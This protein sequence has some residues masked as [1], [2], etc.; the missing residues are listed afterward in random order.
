MSQPTNTALNSLKPKEKG[1]L[2]RYLP[3]IYLRNISW[4]P[5]IL[6]ALFA[7][8]LGGIG[9]SYGS[10]DIKVL[11]FAA[12]AGIIVALAIYQKPELGAY[13]LTIMVFTNASDLLTDEGLP[14]INKPLVALI[15]VSIAANYLLRTGK[16]SKLPEMTRL[17]WALL[18][19][20]LAIVVSTFVAP[21]QGEAFEVVVDVTKDI[22]IGI[23]LFITLNTREKWE[24][25]I[26]LFLV[27]MA[28]VA[29][30]GVIKMAFG[31][32]QTFWGL[33]QLSIFG[34]LDDSGMLRYGGPIGESNM[35]GQVLAATLPIAIYRFKYEKQ[36]RSKALMAIIALLVLLAV[37]YTNSRGAFVALGLILPII[38]LQ[39]KIKPLYMMIA[40]LAIV[41]LFAI[42][43][44]N[45]TQ[46]L[47]S[48]NVFFAPQDEYAIQQD[49]SLVGRANQARAGLAMFQENPI[50]GVGFGNFSANY[51][52]Y[53]N[54]LGLANAGMRASKQIARHPHSLYIEILSETGI[55]GFITFSIFFY[56]LFAG[57]FS[58]RKKYETYVT[59]SDWVSWITALIFSLLTFLVSGLFLHGLLFRY[60]WVLIG[61]ILAALSINRDLLHAVQTRP[62]NNQHNHHG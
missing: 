8:I 17:E 41:S 49:E 29:G 36:T 2:A 30:L 27:V 24:T 16:F 43:P 22:L 19:F 38:M 50:F 12:I 42:L 11:S 26:R 44:A 39:M 53:A 59:D 5:F 9:I 40:G 18:G 10:T 15:F 58:A 28:V 31:L 61:L 32:D 21:K 34:Q 35:W 60:I 14:G 4:T 33:A 6:A 55:M 48:L 46:R 20:Y 13:L 25:C 51:W 54:K 45:Y 7:S 47:M 56:Y 23:I 1:D 52:D 57:L 62:R 37:I 3:E